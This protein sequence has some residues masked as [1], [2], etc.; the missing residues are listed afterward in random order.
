M[1]V[2]LSESRLISYALRGETHLSPLSS[3][4]VIGPEVVHSASVEKRQ[5]SWGDLRTL[6][7]P[8]ESFSAYLGE[9]V[10][11]V[12]PVYKN[13]VSRVQPLVNSVSRLHQAMQTM[14]DNLGFE[15][16]LTYALRALTLHGEL[17]AIASPPRCNPRVRIVREYLSS[18]LET[19]MNL[20]EVS[21]LVELSPFHVVREFRRA[22]GMSPYAFRMQL[23]I[24]KAKELLL[25]GISISEVAYSTGFSDHAH[26]TRTFHRIVGAPP[27]G[28]RKSKNLQDLTHRD[29]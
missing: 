7:I 6:L 3:V 21:R 25:Q 19:N 23:R 28:Y 10:T 2:I 24:A 8:P 1:Q 20:Q 27:S 16:I 9:R 17:P 26:L 4:F 29:C 15:V 11:G 12:V 5:V 18:D 14:K 22:Y 13:P